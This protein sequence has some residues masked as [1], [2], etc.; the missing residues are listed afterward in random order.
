VTRISAPD[1]T[2]QEA[3]LKLLMER[4]PAKPGRTSTDERRLTNSR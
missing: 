4:T 3:A 2:A 1:R